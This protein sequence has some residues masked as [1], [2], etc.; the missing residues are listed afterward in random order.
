MDE[1]IHEGLSEYKKTGN[2]SFMRRT[3]ETWVDHVVFAM[4]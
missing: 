1:I 2:G 3:N 4:S